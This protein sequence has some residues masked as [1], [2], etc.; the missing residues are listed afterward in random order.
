M[1]ATGKGT[2]PCGARA[3]GAQACSLAIPGGCA[4]FASLPAAGRRGLSAL[5]P[6]AC[7]TRKGRSL[8]SL[9]A[10]RVPPI[11]RGFASGSSRSPPAAPAPGV[12][13]WGVPPFPAG[14]SRRPFRRSCGGLAGPVSGSA[15]LGG[16]PW[17]LLLL[18]WFLAAVACWPRFRGVG[19]SASPSRPGA[20][21]GG[22]A[23]RPAL[24]PAPCSLSASPVSVALPRSPRPGR[25]GSASRSRSPR[26][27]ARPAVSGASRC[28][29]RRW[30]ALLFPRRPGLRPAGSSAPSSFPGVS[31]GFLRPVWFSRPCRARAG[32]GGPGGLPSRRAAAVP[33]LPGRSVSAVPARRVPAVRG[34]RLGARVRCGG[35]AGSGLGGPVPARRA[36]PGSPRVRVPRAVR[37][38]CGRRP[39]RPASLGAGWSPWR[40]LFPS[41][42]APPSPPPVRRPGGRFLVPARLCA[43]R[44]RPWRG[45]GFV[46]ARALFGFGGAFA[47]A[48]L[49][50]PSFSLQPA[51][52]PG[53]PAPVSGRPAAVAPAG[54]VAGG[55]FAAASLWWSGFL[56]R[57]FGG[58]FSF[59]PRRPGGRLGGVPAGAG[60]GR[61]LAGVPVAVAA[62]RRRSRPRRALPFAARRGA[63][64]LSR[65]RVRAA[66]GA[67]WPVR[68]AGAVARH[69]GCGAIVVVAPFGWPVRAG[70][71]LAALVR[72]V[73]PARAAPNHARSSRAPA[74]PFL[75]ARF[76]GLFH[77]KNNSISY[78]ID[79]SAC[80]NSL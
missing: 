54:S 26:A 12:R 47:A 49:V 16:V 35:S 78:C 63:A 21:A 15:S 44:S 40:F 79:S 17:L 50:S 19:S 61:S 9:P 36:G 55:W 80:Y 76:R 25:V 27:P 14:R 5:V 71:P 53:S 72:A 7:A 22:C 32:R 33:A 64:L 39:A 23:L 57:G 34:R 65:S 6:F 77:G 56:L 8:R 66:P 3:P 41:L 67:R 31:C 30:F 62:S 2:H 4:R 10:S 24:S 58:A 45:S 48:S 13:G 1:V 75:V 70:V 43:V 38:A 42:P 18:S 37:S 28:R 60:G 69:S 68:P 20:R 46:S 52:R 11:A 29:S 59:F 73:W 51:S 74:F